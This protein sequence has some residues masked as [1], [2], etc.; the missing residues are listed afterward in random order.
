MAHFAKLNGFIVERVEVVNN[1]TIKNLSFP[2]SEPI[3]VEFLKSLYGVDTEWKQTSYNDSFRKNYAGI[4][5][6]YDASLDAFIPP[7][8]YPSWT[9]NINICQW[10]PPTPYP[11]DGKRYIWDETTQT[12]IPVNEN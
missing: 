12:W 3:G 7:Q 5:F 6:T 1:E 9:L 8:P 2:N 10:E 4:G 11:T